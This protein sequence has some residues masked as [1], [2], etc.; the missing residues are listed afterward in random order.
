M[1]NEN[2]IY[3]ITQMM[4]DNQVIRGDVSQAAGMIK[5]MLSEK[6]LNPITRAI[7]AENKKARKN[8]CKEARLLDAL[9]PFMD[10]KNHQAVDKTIDALYMAETLR[11]LS[12]NLP[13]R[14]PIRQHKPASSFVNALADDSVHE[15]GIYDVDARCAA[16]A[17]KPPLSPF[18]VMMALCA[19]RSENRE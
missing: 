6:Y 7:T 1:S 16:Y 15:D 9:K 3:E 4:S 18:F 14:T 8:P 17:G 5:A 2:K 12:A 10:D 19:M 13:V 11:G